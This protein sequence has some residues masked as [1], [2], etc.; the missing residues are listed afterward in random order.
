M[1]QERVVDPFLTR[2]MG[3]EGS[4]FERSGLGTVLVTIARSDE[5][6]L[7][8]YIPACGECKHQRGRIC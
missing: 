8:A 7:M 1:L 5:N 2:F 4:L 3:V 6:D